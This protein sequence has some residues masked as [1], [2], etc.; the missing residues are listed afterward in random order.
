MNNYRK[1]WFQY[2]PIGGGSGNIALECILSPMHVFQT[3]SD[4]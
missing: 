2:S 3:T 1:S 4:Q